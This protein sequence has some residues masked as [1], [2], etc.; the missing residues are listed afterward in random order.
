MALIS[1]TNDLIIGKP[2]GTIVE[3]EIISYIQ[4]LTLDVAINSSLAMTS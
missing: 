3:C 1:G 2:M 4:G